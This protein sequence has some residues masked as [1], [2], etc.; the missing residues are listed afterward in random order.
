M[1]VT[2]EILEMVVTLE[3]G[4]EMEEMEDVI[5]VE[6]MDIGQ[7]IVQMK[8]DEIDVSIV[9]NLVILLANAR[10]RGQEE[11]FILM[12]V[13]PLEDLAL[14]PQEGDLV[15]QDV[16]GR[17]LEENQDHHPQEVQ[18]KLALL[19]EAHISLHLLQ[20][21]IPRDQDPNPHNLK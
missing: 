11:D 2:L 19:Q 16:L 3:I 8:E 10:K 9:E 12:M 13:N 4:E 21:E 17:Q 14:V 7:E 20:M 5:I 1:V 6:R 18:E 15:P